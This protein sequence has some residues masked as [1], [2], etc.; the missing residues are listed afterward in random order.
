MSA[1]KLAAERA[2][3]EAKYP[4]PVH[5]MWV[6]D[7]YVATVYD[8]WDVQTHQA[9]WEGWQ[10]RAALEAKPAPADPLQYSPC[11][12][13]VAAPAA[14]APVQPAFVDEWEHGCNAL[15]TNIKLWT[16]RCPHCGKPAP[17][18]STGGAA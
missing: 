1:D 11:R 14:P 9:R 3:F 7:S 2:A 18:A 5:A 17:E 10:A 16:A 15:L 12:D 4:K 13:Y 8:A 6:G